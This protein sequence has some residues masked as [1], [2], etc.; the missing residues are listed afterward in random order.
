[1]SESEL[2]DICRTQNTAETAGHAAAV[3]LNQIQ[4][5]KE[6]RDATVFTNIP[7]VFIKTW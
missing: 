2:L 7:K 3:T 4:R 5:P 6:Q 1:M